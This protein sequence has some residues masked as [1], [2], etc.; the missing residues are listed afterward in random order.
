ML[1]LGAY[2]SHTRRDSYLGI[3]ESC[4]L[5]SYSQ[6]VWAYRMAITVFR[7]ITRHRIV[8]RCP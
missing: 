4:M 2:Y 6:T 1:A 7:C 3:Y 5:Q 8:M